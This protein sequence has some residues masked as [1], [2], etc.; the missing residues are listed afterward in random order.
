LAI[1]SLSI[2]YPG[3]VIWIGGDAKLPDIEWE[4]MSVVDQH[5]PAQVNSLFMAGEQIV[6]FP[7]RR[8]NL[9]DVFITNRPSLI[10]KC[11]PL[12]GLS[13]YDIVFVDS[14]IMPAQQKP[15]QRLIHQ[16]KK[17]NIPDTGADLKGNLDTTFQTYDTKTPAGTP[18]NT[19]KNTCL[20][21][22][23]KHVLS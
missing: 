3:S 6:D 5:N 4:T 8:Q 21:N 11:R 22:I 20:D 16:W 13:D 9:F 18:W 19:F 1:S 14:N 7:T 2:K 15:P 23:Q 12:P 10:N 17:V